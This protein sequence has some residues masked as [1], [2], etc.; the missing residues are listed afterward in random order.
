MLK[1][2]VSGP[3]VALESS[4]AW[5]RVVVPSSPNGSAALLTVKVVSSRRSSNKS[6]LKRT[7]G[8]LRL[9]VRIQRF[10]RLNS[11]MAFPS[12][13]RHEEEPGLQPTGQRPTTSRPDL[14]RRTHRCQLM[15]ASPKLNLATAAFEVVWTPGLVQPDP[16]LTVLTQL[17]QCRAGNRLKIRV[18][19]IFQSLFGRFLSQVCTGRMISIGTPSASYRTRW[20]GSGVALRRIRR[21][22]FWSVGRTIVAIS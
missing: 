22:P 10:T 13:S 14:P 16:D 17:P 21:T 9:W 1:S 12:K 4:I 20:S 15:P 3:G 6:K 2:I 8:R 18:P 7:G 11:F 19:S 5:R